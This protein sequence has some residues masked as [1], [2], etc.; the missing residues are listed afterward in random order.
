MYEPLYLIALVA[1]GIWVLHQLTTMPPLTA[2]ALAGGPFPDDHPPEDEKPWERLLMFKKGGSAPKADPNVGKAAMEN[3]QLG[4]D[5]LSF[6]KDQFAVENQRQGTID[7]LTQQIGQQQLETQDQA[8]RWA[9]EDRA[10]W[11]D[12]FQPL[13]DDFIREASEWGSEGRQAAAAGE[14]RADVIR[15]SDMQRQMAARDMAR[16]GI[17]PRSGRYA[18]VNAAQDVGTALAAAGASNAARDQVRKEGMAMRADAINLGRGLPSQA[19]GAAGLGLSAGNS[20]LGNYMGAAGNARA[21]AGMMGQ[22]FQGAMGANQSAAGIWNQQHQNQMQAWAAQQQAAATGIA[23]I[24]GALGT[25]GG[26]GIMAMSDENVKENKRPV[27]G[28]LAAINGLDV[29]AWNY[30]DGTTNP[31]TGEVLDAEVTHI[32]PY[33]QDFQR[34]TGMGDGR[35]IDMISSMGLMMK[36]IQELDDKVEQIAAGKAR[37]RKPAAEAQHAG[38]MA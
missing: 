13:E 10:R 14:A 30:K 26:V 16:M 12:T 7:E 8:N 38:G 9:R 31:Q 1:L 15:S 34:E 5:W 4:K 17:D 24:T 6:A 32:G 21:N 18:G 2:F 35:T 37:R 11:E 25:L 29:E 23:G 3:V 22:G 19:A 33:A 27:D 36:G 20:A 28:A